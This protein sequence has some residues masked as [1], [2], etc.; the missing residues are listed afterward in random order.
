M[1]YIDYAFYKSLY[2]EDIAEQEFNRFAFDASRIMDNCTSGVDGVKKLEIAFPTKESDALAVK[3]C[4]CKLIQMCKELETAEAAYR[5]TKN[6]DGQYST[7][8]VASVSS[9]SESVS[10][11]VPDAFSAPVSDYSERRK[12]FYNLVSSYLSGVQ[13]AN[14]VNLLYGGR[15]PVRVGEGLV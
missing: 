4:I 2:G 10:Y 5:I 11:K 13:D 9:G 7:G 6:A 12:A 15:Y 8:V 3:H 14:G 1:A